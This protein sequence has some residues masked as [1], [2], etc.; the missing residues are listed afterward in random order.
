[1][2]MHRFKQQHDLIRRA[3]LLISLISLLKETLG[4]GWTNAVTVFFD[5]WMNEID[6]TSP[7]PSVDRSMN[8]ILSYYISQTMINEL[9]SRKIT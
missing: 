1:M 7:N 5:A 4:L 8:D 2:L 9:G 6:S 3:R